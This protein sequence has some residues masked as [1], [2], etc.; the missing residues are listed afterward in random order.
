MRALIGLYILLPAYLRFLQTFPKFWA[1][2]DQRIVAAA[3][4]KS[5]SPRK[6]TACR[7]MNEWDG[8]CWKT[9]CWCPPTSLWF[10]TSLF[11]ICCVCC[12]SSWFRILSSCTQKQFGYQ[13]FVER[14]FNATLYSA[15]D[16]SSSGTVY[17]TV[18]ATPLFMRY[19]LFLP[20]AAVILSYFKTF[21]SLVT[22]YY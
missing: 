12:C 22:V 13:C 6:Q 16:I 1:T 5:R 4:C 9:H 17:I 20:T 8:T 15:S 11:H 14:Y 2:A 10:V 18:S 3:C 21:S 7:A 19:A